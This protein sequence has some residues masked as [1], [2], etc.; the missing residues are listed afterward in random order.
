MALLGTLRGQLDAK[1]YEKII[2]PTLALTLHIHPMITA[3]VLLAGTDATEAKTYQ[4]E[5]VD[6]AIRKR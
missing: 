6:S 1:G 2:H 3:P 5:L 4:Q